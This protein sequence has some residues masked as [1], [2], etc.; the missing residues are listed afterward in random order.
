[1]I[2]NYGEKI[3]N[4]FNNRKIIDY[5]ISLIERK[6]YNKIIELEK[7]NLLLMINLK[8]IT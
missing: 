6:E 2:L 8:K 5:I 4:Y 3:R 1:M 7:K